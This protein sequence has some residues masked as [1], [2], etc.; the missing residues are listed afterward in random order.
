MTEKA[1]CHVDIHS[2]LCSIKNKV[3][4]Q[5]KILTLSPFLTSDFSLL[6]QLFVCVIFGALKMT[7]YWQTE[8]QKKKGTEMKKMSF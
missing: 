4:Q 3:L 2:L 7:S 1:F 5:G 6:D 8:K